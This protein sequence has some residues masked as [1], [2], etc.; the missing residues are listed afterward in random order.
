MLVMSV[1]LDVSQLDMS[2]LNCPKPLKRSDMSVMAETSQLA[3]EPYVSVAAVALALYSWA[4]ACRELFSA[5][6]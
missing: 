2:A 5:K 4:A 1:T 3:M 6:A